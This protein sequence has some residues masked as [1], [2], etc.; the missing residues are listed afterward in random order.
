[1]LA[2]RV[3]LRVPAA[4]AAEYNDFWVLMQTKISVL[5]L[6]FQWL[7]SNMILLGDMADSRE[8]FSMRELGESVYVM[9]VAL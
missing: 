5:C 3:L 1:M 8:D 6:V 7:S 2:A 9:L 4:T